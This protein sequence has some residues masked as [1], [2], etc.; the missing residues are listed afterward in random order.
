MF[1]G[2]LKILR[3][4][5]YRLRRVL[6]LRAHFRPDE[7]VMYYK[8]E[9]LSYIEGFTV[10]IYHASGYVLGMLDDLQ[11]SFLESLGVTCEAA[12]LKYRL[13][14]LGSRRDMAML[15]L[16]HRANLGLLP[17]PLNLL[18]PKAS[19]TLHSHGFSTGAP[20]QRQMA[21]PV[22]PGHGA[23]FKR[24]V[25]GAIAVYNRLPPSTVTAD[26]TKLFQKR[27]QQ[28]LRDNIGKANWASLFHRTP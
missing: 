8:S 20:H 15:G 21:D 22:Q 24:S 18:F 12:F 14:P 25:F 27:L 3:E 7:L 19:G 28:Q 2:V 4:A 13:A 26:S 17:S 9:V 1:H 23:I 10:G 16:L 6:R 5:S 11:A